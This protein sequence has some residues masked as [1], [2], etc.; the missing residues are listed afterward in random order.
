MIIEVLIGAGSLCMGIPA[1]VLGCEKCVATM[2][3]S[4][5]VGS[6]T[7]RGLDPEQK[8]CGVGRGDCW[9]YTQLEQEQQEHNDG[10]S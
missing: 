7:W 3:T 1:A 4:A 8:C 6:A 10:S 5:D 9:D 2:A